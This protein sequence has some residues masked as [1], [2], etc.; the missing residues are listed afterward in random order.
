MTEPQRK[1]CSCFSYHHEMAQPS[2]F[3][4]LPNPEISNLLDVAL[5]HRVTWH[6]KFQGNMVVSQQWRPQ[7]HRSKSLRT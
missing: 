2:S 1:T 7:I 6:S 5:C 4:I 3:T